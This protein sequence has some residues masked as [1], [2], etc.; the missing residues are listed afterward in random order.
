MDVLDDSH[1]PA[2]TS[3]GKEVSVV[4]VGEEVTGNF[5]LDDINLGNPEP[6][7]RQFRLSPG[8]S[9]TQKVEKHT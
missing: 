2:L 8:L 4:A 9:H 6:Q 3:V 1:S 5:P 7:Q